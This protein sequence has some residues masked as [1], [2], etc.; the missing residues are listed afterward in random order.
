MGRGAGAVGASIAEGREEKHPFQGRKPPS[1]VH[2]QVLPTKRALKMAMVI[3]QQWGLGVEGRKERGVGEGAEAHNWW[4]WSRAH[5]CVL[6]IMA[7]FPCVLN[8]IKIKN[9]Q[10][11]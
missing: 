1:D 8:F 6:S 11:I 2:L 5:E 3:R 10:K 4:T 7:T 9:Y